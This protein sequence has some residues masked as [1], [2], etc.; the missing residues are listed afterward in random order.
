MVEAIR[1]C[2]DSLGSEDKFVQK[3]PFNSKSINLILTRF[4]AF[5][6]IPN[7]T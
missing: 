1:N 6:L 4:F 7:E 3:K 2:E 5:V